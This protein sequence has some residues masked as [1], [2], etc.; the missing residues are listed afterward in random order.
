MNKKCFLIKENKLAQKLGA[1]LEGR[2]GSGL[3]KNVSMAENT[4]P[5]PE[6]KPALLKTTKRRGKFLSC[7]K[8]VCGTTLIRDTDA[9]HFFNIIELT[10]FWPEEM[11]HNI[12]GIHDNPVALCRAF[13][14]D[15]FQPAN[16]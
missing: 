6:E 10:H 11:H 9:P 13:N 4:V 5:V 3:Y 14:A 8:P 12:T 15:I 7:L 2:S 1:Y 16:V